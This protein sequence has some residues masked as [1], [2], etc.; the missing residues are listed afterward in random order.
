MRWTRELIE[1]ALV[2]QGRYYLPYQLHA[3]PQQF[4]RAFPEAAA[5]RSLKA[6]V[7]PAGKLSNTL[8]LK[9]L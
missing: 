4:E 5:L 8:W 9:Y 7:D 3:T 6:V 2:H 1:L